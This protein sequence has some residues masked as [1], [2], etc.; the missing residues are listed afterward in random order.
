MV[1]DDDATEDGVLEATDV[2]VEFSSPRISE[3]INPITSN[4]SFI[5]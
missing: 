5:A 1:L 4:S 2:A 3:N